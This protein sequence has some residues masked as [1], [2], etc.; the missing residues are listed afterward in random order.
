M[1]AA[2]CITNKFSVT[3]DNV[4]FY[5]VNVVPNSYYPTVESM[6][7]IYAGVN[8]ISFLNTG[9]IPGYPSVKISVKKV[10]RVFIL[11]TL[12]K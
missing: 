3:L 10:I 6:F 9:T 1:S 11:R 8:D 2:S 4:N 5:T 7:D 12:C